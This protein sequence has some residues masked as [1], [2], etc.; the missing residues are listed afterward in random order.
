M[1]SVRVVI[2]ILWAASLRAAGASSCPPT[3]PVELEVNVDSKTFLE[4]SETTKDQDLRHGVHEVDSPVTLC[5]RPDSCFKV[6]VKGGK[7]T[8]GGRVCELEECHGC[9]SR[10]GT[11]SWT[12]QPSKMLEVFNR[13]RKL[14]AAYS[15]D[16][17]MDCV[18]T[19]DEC[20]DDSQCDPDQFCFFTTSRKKQRMLR[21][22]EA[23][24]DNNKNSKRSLLF[25]SNAVGQCVCV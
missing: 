2:G 24:S 17:D 4:F 12:Q 25:G 15:Y 21:A 16:Y 23:S 11:V 14:Q 3:S 6:M 7:A 9:I 22:E 5:G 10:E 19:L 20:V 1:L 8:M 18:S 13:V